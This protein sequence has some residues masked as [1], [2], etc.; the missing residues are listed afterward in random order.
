MS[1]ESDLLFGLLALQM[2][3]I[4]KEQLLEGAAVWM[5]EPKGD[6]P[7]LFLERKSLK[8]SQ[9][10]AVKLMV[11][12]QLK[13]NEGDAGRSL[14]GLSPKAVLESLLALNVPPDVRQSLAWVQARGPEPTRTKVAEPGFLASAAEGRYRLGAELG[15]GGLGRVVEAYDAQLKRDVAVKLV[16][17]DLPADLAERFVREAELAARLEHPS[18]VPVHDFGLLPPSTGSPSTGSGLAGQSGKKLFLCMRRIRGRDLGKLL[19]S[20]AEG[21]R[22]TRRTY[23]RARLLRI[24]QD[25]C[26]GMAY[27]HDR[28]VIHR[29]LKPANVMIGDYGET[30]IVD[31]GLARVMG[32]GRPETGVP[33]SAPSG[34]GKPPKKGG[35]AA[36]SGLDLTMEGDI[37]GTPAYMPPEQAAGHVQEMDHRS[38]VYALGAILYEV[39][40]L[41]P[42]F[43]GRTRHEIL[44]KVRSGKVTPPSSRVGRE[45]SAP[46]P[47]GT[48]IRAP[49]TLLAADSIP[50]ELDA[51]CVKALAFRREDR[52]QTATE[53]HDEIQLFVEG[54]KEQERKQREA[55]ERVEAGRQWFA[56]YRN[57]RGK[58]EAQ[59]R[60]VKALDDKIEPSQP[61]EE[62][63]PLWDAEAHLRALR[64]ERIEAFANSS[65]EFGQALTV[66]PG[67]V[68]ASDGKC[69][70]FLDRF[71]DAEARRDGE[72]ALLNRKTLA[73]YDREG[74]Y[75][76]R[77]DAPGKLA[78]SV[79]RYEC[80]CLRPVI[81][82]EW[83]VDVAN[84][85][86][87]PWRDGR[88]RPDLELT[89]E[90]AVV[91]EVRTFPAGVQWGHSSKCVRRQL[92][93][94]EVRIAKYTEHERRLI[95]GPERVLGVTPFAE[96]VLPQGSWRCTLRHEEYADVLLP[97]RMDR[98]E[99]WT[100]QV[101]MYRREEIPEGFCCVS[102]GRFFYGGPWAGG[103]ELESKTTEDLFV[104]RFA[105]TCAEYT[106]FLN[107]LVSNG[108][109]QEARDRQPREGERTWWIE[110]AGRFRLPSGAEDNRFSW[111][112]RWP[113]FSI[114]WFDAMAYAAWKSKREGRVYRLMHDE[115]F[116]M[117]ARGVD[118]RVFSFG[119]EYDGNYSHTCFSIPGK[120][121][122]M[123]VDSFPSDES[124]SGIRGLSGGV[125]T[126]A[127][128]AAPVPL[129]DS[130]SIRGGGWSYPYL[131]ARAA[132]KRCI[133]PER[134]GWEIGIRLA[135]APRTS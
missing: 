59:E 47:D 78:L 41:H 108:R 82:P 77:L 29:D 112:P 98:G 1:R 11:E 131:H 106:E 104:A 14:A 135:S 126:W 95:L 18:I 8:P 42:P 30:L 115:E 4:T 36:R 61:L 60:T 113:V 109:K 76:L 100:Q 102:G 89:S 50:P 134:T 132:L 48:V 65:A 107:D 9:H 114:N 122:P 31:W 46:D 66:D 92:P 40:T 70:L 13:A 34:S 27:A 101:T 55:R 79:F 62:K 83:R 123:P 130:R 119:N 57:A 39:L 19:A 94:V 23:T 68:D 49:S 97:V 71:L 99:V 103:G 2:N 12:E 53:F 16:L 51:I 56:R 105:T 20:I 127:Y 7:K 85:A 37:L 54:V 67:S 125:L 17:D 45:K 110:D 84:T 3:F 5:S 15:K 81:H 28:G 6:L 91:P 120:L 87:I 72:E 43:E 58:V 133:P 64:E 32:A 121:S 75:A 38:D 69:D 116:E 90:D 118:A 128:N 63:R 117:A 25:I 21:D 86:S 73:T 33:A 52:Y 111:D 10:A 24:V 93:G 124:P 80:N 22:E 26:L 96:V 88:P 44:E 35:G 74:K 129:R